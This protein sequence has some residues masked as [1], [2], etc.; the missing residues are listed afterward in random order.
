M[1]DG[2]TMMGVPLIIEFVK[3]HQLLDEGHGAQWFQ[4]N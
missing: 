1:V 4:N 2:L 3:H